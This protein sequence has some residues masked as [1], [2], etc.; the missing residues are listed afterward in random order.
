MKQYI[1]AN[2]SIVGKLPICLM[3]QN[4]NKLDD[5]HVVLLHV[6]RMLKSGAGLLLYDASRCR[7][8]QRWESAVEIIATM[9]DG[10]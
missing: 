5:E 6:K 9:K 1:S 4:K 7:R 8:L 10:T 3:I 2:T